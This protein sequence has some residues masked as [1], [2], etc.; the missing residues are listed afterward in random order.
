MEMGDRIRELRLKNKLTQD[1]LA[2]KLGLQKSAI[3][4]YENGRVENIKRSMI[5]KMSLVFGV[6]PAY[7]MGWEEE[8][9]ESGIVYKS[10]DHKTVIEAIEEL[11]ADDI[12]II[13]DMVNRLK[14]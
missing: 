1:E 5:Q 11:S 4:K 2:E 12:K 7:L 8:K 3:A 13:M 10:N 6:S 9:E 14:K